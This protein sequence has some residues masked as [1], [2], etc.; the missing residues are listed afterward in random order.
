MQ[1]SGLRAVSGAGG[2]VSNHRS[3]CLHP[4]RGLALGPVPN[5]DEYTVSGGYFKSPQAL[6]ANADIPECPEQ[7]HEIIVW[8]AMLFYARYE[9]APEIYQDAEI[10]Y[11]RMFAE[12]VIDQRPTMTSGTFV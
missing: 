3:F 1:P 4:N 5:A 8:R 7:F 2:G 12:L 6:S 11:N 10:N 9:A